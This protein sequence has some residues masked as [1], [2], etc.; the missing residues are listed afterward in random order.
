MIHFLVRVQGHAPLLVDL[1]ILFNPKTLEPRKF[2]MGDFRGAAWTRG[3]RREKPMVIRSW[4][5][6]IVQKEIALEIDVY[7]QASDSD[8][9][10]FC[11]T[12]MYGLPSSFFL[13]PMTVCAPSMLDFFAL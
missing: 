10:A 7:L 12:Y 1:P 3:K 5:A 2:F 4:N 8:Q 13:E 9:P 11:P 6:D